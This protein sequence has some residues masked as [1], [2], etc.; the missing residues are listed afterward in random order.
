MVNRA[1]FHVIAVDQRGH[2]L[3]D[4]PHSPS[5]YSMDTLVADVQQ[6]L[7]VVKQYLEAKPKLS[8]LRIEGHTDNDGTKDGNQKLSELRAMAVAR[9]LL[10]Q[11]G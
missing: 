4:K 2:G 9:W 3:S 8:L 1:G 7:D 11:G 6:V 5:A 10:P